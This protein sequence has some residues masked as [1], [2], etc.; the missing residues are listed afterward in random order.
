MKDNINSLIDVYIKENNKEELWNLAEKYENKIDLEKIANYYIEEKS[1]F[2]ICE[3]ISLVGEYL[4]LDEIFEKIIATKDEE[5]IFWIV[6]NPI[7]KNIID[8]NYLQKL[9]NYLKNGK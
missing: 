9:N 4:N 3:L 2:Y 1:D 7:I 5:F 6:K 8:D